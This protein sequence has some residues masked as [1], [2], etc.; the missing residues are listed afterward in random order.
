MSHLCPLQW[1]SFCPICNGKLSQ[2]L[3]LFSVV[4]VFFNN[5]VM[6]TTLYAYKQKKR[7]LSL[8]FLSQLINFYV[9]S[10]TGSFI[11]YNTVFID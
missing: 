8:L 2:F 11:T 1:R 7:R 9:I 10:N 3:I 4:L 6:A 5:I